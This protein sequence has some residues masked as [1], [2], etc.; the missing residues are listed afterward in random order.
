VYVAGREVREASHNPLASQLNPRDHIVLRR[1]YRS[2]TRGDGDLQ[3][4]RVV[5]RS[6]HRKGGDVKPTSLLRQ[7]VVRLN[8]DALRGWQKATLSFAAPGCDYLGQ[9]AVAGPARVVADVID[10]CDLALIDHN[11][12]KSLVCYERKEAS[13]LLD[14]TTEQRWK[15]RVAF[16]ALDL[17]PIK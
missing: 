12:S 6:K 14:E 1:G 10:V 5:A 2:A 3:D 8:P 17:S 11:G 7:N 13:K 15:A 4:F 16:R 9:L